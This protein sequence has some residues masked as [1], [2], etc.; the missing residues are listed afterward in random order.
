MV[1]PLDLAAFCAYA[2]SLAL[3]LIDDVRQRRR[4]RE[5]RETADLWRR[6]RTMERAAERER[7]SWARFQVSVLRA[8]LADRGEDP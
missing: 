1:S 6:L 5:A 2:L 3:Y 7:T 4:V 8:E